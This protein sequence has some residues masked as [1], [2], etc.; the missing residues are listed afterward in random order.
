MKP[1]G[2]RTS[3]QREKRPAHPVQQLLPERDEIFTYPVPVPAGTTYD[4]LGISPDAADTEIGSAKMEKARELQS[5][6]RG[7]EADL[8]VVYDAVPGLRDAE[9]R[10]KE[11]NDQKGSGMDD[12]ALRTRIFELERKAREQLPDFVAKRGQVRELERKLLELN[13]LALDQ[14]DKRLAYDREHP[15]LALLKLAEAQSLGLPEDRTGLFLLRQEVARFL[16]ERGEKVFHPSD[17]TREDFT[18]DFE[19]NPVLDGREN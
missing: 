11:L 12:K 3:A 5:E 1:R 4:D 6:K 15:P 7:I 18:S 9:D 19:T 2:K 10:V 14:R 17:W 8:K 13:A 16:E